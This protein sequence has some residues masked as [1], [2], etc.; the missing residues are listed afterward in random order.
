MELF[1]SKNVDFLGKRKIAFIISGTIILLGIIFFFIN[2]GFNYSIDFTGGTMLEVRFDETVNVG[3]IR[4]LIKGLD[5]GEP[6][7]QTFSAGEKENNGVLIRFQ[8]E[9]NE[10]V[11]ADVTSTIIS[12]LKDNYEGLTDANISTEHIGP[13][14]GSELRATALKAILLSLVLMLLYIWIRF[15]FRFG[16]AAIAALIHDVLCTLA[17]FTI[18]DQRIGLTVV[19]A[20]LTIIGYSINDTIVISDRIRENM[21]VL[22][23]KKFS[24]LVNI[25]LNQVFSRTIITSVAVFLV[26]LSI[27]LFGGSVIFEFSLALL[28]GVIFGTYSS[29]FI[30]SPIVVEWEKRMPKKVLKR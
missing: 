18:L 14:I 27:F 6:T 26:V 28:V 2:G 12:A 13:K 3:E 10:N 8:G 21:K 22:F 30:V 9:K 11:D 5:V 15:Q 16:V 1:T 4:S 20:L 17:V 25:S 7:V 19:A 29:I 24:E 23:R